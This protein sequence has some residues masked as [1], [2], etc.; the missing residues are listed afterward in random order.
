MS[1]LF[2]L[3]CIALKDRAVHLFNL[4][5]DRV[6]VIGDETKFDGFVDVGSITESNDYEQIAFISNH[7]D[8]VIIDRML[9]IRKYSI[10]RR[11]SD[12]YIDS[13]QGD[14]FII[15][16]SFMYGIIYK[17]RV[18]G[19]EFVKVGEELSDEPYNYQNHTFPNGSKF[20]WRNP[21]RFIN[22][23]G[24]KVELDGHDTT[25]SHVLKVTDKY[26]LRK[27][28]SNKVIWT[29]YN[30]Y[31]HPQKINFHVYQVAEDATAT[32]ENTHC[33]QFGKN[34]WDGI[35]PPE[36][37]IFPDGS[38]LLIVKIQDGHLY[39]HYHTKDVAYYR[40][41]NCIDR[42]VDIDGCS[43]IYPLKCLQKDVNEGINEITK[44]L[45]PSIVKDLINVVIQYLIVY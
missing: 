39:G 20:V 18:V 6:D 11:H 37:A 1:T 44:S 32:F 19:E 15:R 26:S 42:E 13:F 36:V 27:F 17:Y 30:H 45:P 7:R 35:I 31:L 5:L 10:S 29:K 12:M 3:K 43:F 28:F 14:E 4:D 24:Q 41:S 40:D 38:P 22:S 33:L 16:I 8:I 23:S 21:D 25:K 34:D 2:P 9:S